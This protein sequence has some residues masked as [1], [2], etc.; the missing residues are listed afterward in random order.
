MVL[1]CSRRRFDAGVLVLVLVLLV[2]SG[3]VGEAAAGAG[4]SFDPTTTSNDTRRP[5]HE[6]RASRRA[7]R[8][9]QDP[10]RRRRIRA[11]AEAIGVT[12]DVPDEPPDRPGH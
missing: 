5:G 6:S 4:R 10:G 2:V 1:L 3:A 7:G 8:S 9:E 11:G 12:P